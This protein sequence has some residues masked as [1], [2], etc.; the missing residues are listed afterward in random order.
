M[1][2]ILPDLIPCLADSDL[3]QQRVSRNQRGGQPLEIDRGRGQERLDAHILQ[4]G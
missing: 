3:L 2:G 1:P 4:R